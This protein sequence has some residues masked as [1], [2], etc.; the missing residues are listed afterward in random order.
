MVARGHETPEQAAQPFEL[1]IEQSLL[2]RCDRVGS[3]RIDRDAADL[4]HFRALRQ[5]GRA[6]RPAGQDQESQSREPSG[7]SHCKAVHIA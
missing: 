5:R 7:V 3:R 4:K 1:A 6:R 2:A